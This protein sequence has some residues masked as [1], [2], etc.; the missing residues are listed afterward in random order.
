MASARPQRK[1]H[2]AGKALVP[3]YQR[4]QRTFSLLKLA[5][6]RFLVTKSWPTDQLTKF[7]ASVFSVHSLHHAAFRDKSKV[8]VKQIADLTK[9]SVH[10]V[11][12]LKKDAN[13]VV[14]GTTWVSAKSSSKRR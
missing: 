4:R 8:V 9:R 5:I 3:L 14:R 13:D 10:A 7:F 6:S 1:L 12:R 11:L 2:I